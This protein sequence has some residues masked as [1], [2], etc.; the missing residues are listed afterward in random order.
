LRTRRVRE[1]V[2]GRG[3]ELLYLLPCS[4]DLNPTKEAIA[5]LCF[6]W[7]LSISRIRLQTL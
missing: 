1:I 6:E 7:S 4:P 5:K 2:E 3:C